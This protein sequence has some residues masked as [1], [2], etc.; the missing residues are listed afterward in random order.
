MRI[1]ILSNSDQGY[2]FLKEHLNFR[3]VDE[4]EGLEYVKGKLQNQSVLV[5]NSRNLNL[6]QFIKLT[7]QEEIGCILSLG[8]I[9]QCSAPLDSGDVLV[10]GQVEAISVQPKL[11]DWC[12]AAVDE[13]EDLAGQRVVVGV[14]TNALP[15]QSSEGDVFGVDGQ[16]GALAAACDE[17]GLAALFIR[18]IKGA[19]EDVSDQQFYNESQ[20]KFFRLVKGILDQ[21]NKSRQ[22]SI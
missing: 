9:E 1:A 14:L 3:Q 5:V 6:H 13:C 21:I 16:A 15:E 7:S 2:S 20:Q 11:V 12:L 17:Q 8:Y 22:A 4:N 18:I 19:G 10:A